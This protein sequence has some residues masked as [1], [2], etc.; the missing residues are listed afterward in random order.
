MPLPRVVLDTDCYNEVDDQFALAH[1]LM[2]P[3]KLRLEA[4]YAAPF[5]NSRSSGPAEG[6]EKSYEEILRVLDLVK[7]T[8]RPPV[9][10]GS[11]A[12]LPSANEPVESPMVTDLV[13]R[14]RTTP[15][16]ERLTVVAIGAITNVASALLTAPD[17][18]EK[19][20]VVWL[21]GH[22]PY[23]DHTK[24]FNLKQDLHA[25]RVVLDSPAPLVLVPC[26]PV[27]SHLLTT[28]AELEALLAP[29][30]ALGKYLTDIV[31]QYNGKNEPAWSKVIWDI[32][33]SAWVINPAW[34]RVVDAPSPVL[35]DDVTWDP[36]PGPRHLIKIVRSLNRDAIFADFFAKA[37]GQ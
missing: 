1:L 10:R 27:T 18:A 21:G 11:T 37:K 15:E 2:S 28:V 9:Y 36:A 33:A 23:W 30:S 25:A 16:G 35:R 24:E 26:E 3:E 4:V 19:I 31:R 8:E 32:A 29:Y 14:A 7:T 22:A 34:L 12:W 13:H 6:M 20:E 5:H 17:I